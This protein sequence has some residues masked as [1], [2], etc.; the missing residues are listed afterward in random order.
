M[1]FFNPTK[2]VF[3]YASRVKFKLERK[4]IFFKIV[5]RNLMKF[6]IFYSNLFFGDLNSVFHNFHIFDCF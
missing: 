4:N 3:L 5:I 1:A 2:H 6:L